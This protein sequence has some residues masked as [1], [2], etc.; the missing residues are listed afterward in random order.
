[1]DTGFCL[2]R[3]SQFSSP[4]LITETW[5]LGGGGWWPGKGESWQMEGLAHGGLG[6]WNAWWWVMHTRAEWEQLWRG[7]WK[8]HLWN[9]SRNPDLFLQRRDNIRQNHPAPL[10]TDTHPRKRL[11]QGLGRRGGWGWGLGC[12]HLWVSLAVFS[13]FSFLFN[14]LYM[15]LPP[16]SQCLC[17]FI[18]FLTHLILN[19]F[20]LFWFSVLVG[21]QTGSWTKSGMSAVSVNKILLQHSHAHFFMRCVWLLSHDQGRVK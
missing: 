2:E 9:L 1:M 5:L 12:L 8:A 19:F 17:R 16:G 18:P 20:R 21:W 14:S 13:A 4:E 6:N 15:F 11:N 10:K 7:R 3:L